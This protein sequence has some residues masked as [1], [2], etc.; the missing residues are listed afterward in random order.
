[1][2]EAQ[3][4]FTWGVVGFLM[5]IAAMFLGVAGHE[6]K[7]KKWTVIAFLL[8]IVP[9][10]GFVYMLIQAFIEIYSGFGNGT[11]GYGYPL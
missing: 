3:F 6:T 11:D 10:T 8:L 7:N 2:N 1:M 9:A 4:Y 5:I